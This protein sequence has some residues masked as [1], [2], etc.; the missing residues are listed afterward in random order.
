MSDT[1]TTGAGVQSPGPAGGKW[2]RRWERSQWSRRSQTPICACTHALAHTCTQAQAYR[3]AHMCTDKQALMHAR[4]HTSSC[5]PAPAFK[6]TRVTA[7]EKRHGEIWNTSWACC[8]GSGSAPAASSA[9]SHCRHSSPALA[10]P[11]PTRGPEAS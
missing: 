1:G 8:Q 4:A 2:S 11:G 3:H 10:Q 5:T 6:C 9:P 7:H